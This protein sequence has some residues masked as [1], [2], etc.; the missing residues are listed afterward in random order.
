M[1]IYRLIGNAHGTSDAPEL[2]ERLSAWHDA[3]VAHERFAGSRRSCDEDCPHVDAA[4]LWTE[5]A[6]LFGDRAD[7]LVFLRSR[8]ENGGAGA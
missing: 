3:M 1:N 6:T 8:A 4:A 5:A 7:E 2:A